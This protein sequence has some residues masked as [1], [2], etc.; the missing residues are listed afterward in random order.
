MNI[1]IKEHRWACASLSK[2]FPEIAKAVDEKTYN[3][4]AKNVK[5][6]YGDIGKLKH[7]F[8]PSQSNM[9]LVTLPELIKTIWLHPYESKVVDGDVMVSQ[10]TGYRRSLSD[11]FLMVNS[12]GFRYHIH[13]VLDTIVN[14]NVSHRHLLPNSYGMFAFYC[15]DID[16]FVSG[17]QSRYSQLYL[18]HI[19]GNDNEIFGIDPILSNYGQIQLLRNMI[20]D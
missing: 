13:N 19:L 18:P 9:N 16:R 1:K 8:M 6:L 4:V 5:K 17:I 12:G 10:K 7:S 3:E 11:I 20:I 15:N 2:N 14:Y